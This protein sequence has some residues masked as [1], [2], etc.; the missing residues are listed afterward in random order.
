VKAEDP[1]TDPV[2]ED[3]PKTDPDEVGP[4]D[5]NTELGVDEARLGVPK[6][7]VADEA[8]ATDPK[9]ELIDETVVVETPNPEAAEAVTA[10]DVDPVELTA[11]P[12]IDNPPDATIDVDPPKIEPEDGVDTTVPVVA[13]EPKTEE[14][15]T[16]DSP[17]KAEIDGLVV[18]E[19][20]T[21]VAAVTMPDDEVDAVIDDSSEVLPSDATGFNSS[22]VLLSSAGVSSLTVSTPVDF[23]DE[24]SLAA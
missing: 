14:L 13:E 12:K 7:E 1:K 4:D 15:P 9:V 18:V 20:N 3:E 5:P 23:S 11:D 2:V 22:T 16:E 17:P 24:T 10:T 21:D 19:A 6:T 8:G